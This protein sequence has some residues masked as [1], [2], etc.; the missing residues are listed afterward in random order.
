[1]RLINIKT[2]EIEEFFSTQAPKYYALSHTWLPAGEEVSL[3]DWQEAYQKATAAPP[4]GFTEVTHWIVQRMRG[5]LQKLNK[6]KGLDKISGCMR[7]ASRDVSYCWVDTVCIDKSSSAELSEAINSM[8]KIYQNCQVCIA[9]LAD[10]Q[11]IGSEPGLGGQ[12]QDHLVRSKWFT[13]GWTVSCFTSYLVFDVN[14][15]H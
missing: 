11:R 1:M 4:L 8:F 2:Y 5:S 15:S 13:R 9:Y 10:I 3:R 14:L 6:T 12:G 7:K